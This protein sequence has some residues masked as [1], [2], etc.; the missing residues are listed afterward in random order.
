MIINDLPK[1]S[2]ISVKAVQKEILKTQ[3]TISKTNQST[4]LIFYI[5]SRLAQ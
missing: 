3:S 4:N 1:I 5:K 2:K